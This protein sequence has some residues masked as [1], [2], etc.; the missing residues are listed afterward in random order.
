M[1]LAFIQSVFI[2]S[3]VCLHYMTRIYYKSEWVKRVYYEQAMTDPLTHLPNL[4]ALEHH[5]VQYP[6]GSLCCLRLAN[7]EFLSRHYGVMVQ[8]HCKKTVTGQLKPLL[9]EGECVF[10]F[11]GSELLVFLRGPDPEARLK[12]MVTLLNS[13]KILWHKNTLDI[14]VGGSWGVLDHIT[15]DELQ[16]MLGQLSY[17]AEQASRVGRILGL[18]NRQAAITGQTT[19]RVMLLHQVK[20][21]LQGNG[22]RLYVQPILNAAGKGYNEVLSRMFYQNTMITPDKFIPIVAEFNLSA[23]FDMLV[24]RKAVEWLRDHKPTGN[25]PVFSINLMPLTLTQKD[26]ASGIIAMFKNAGVAANRVI[27]EVTESQ[28]FSDEG[29]VASN[30]TQLRK[31]GLQIA[32]DDFGTG[33]SNYARLKSLQAD[34]IKIDGCL[35]KDIG[36]D[37]LDNMIVK[38]ICDMAK[39]RHLKVVAE[40]VETAEQRTLLLQLGVDYLQGYL[41]G[42]PVPLAS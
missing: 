15:S 2:S 16:R 31:F 30:I 21:A 40:F 28:A 7:L 33:Y 38:S 32:I 3:T 25:G 37:P 34:I 39:A 27:V 12:H 9:Q 4:R 11:P 5:L 23:R 6:T 26:I 17:L 22:V 18:D 1:E 13:R 20:E 36:G 24:M 10:Q 19:E 41:I 29:V 8:V 35:I 14:S 42:K